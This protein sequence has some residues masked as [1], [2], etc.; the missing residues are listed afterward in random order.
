MCIF[1][2]GDK[3]IKNGA[4]IASGTVRSVFTTSKGHVRVV[5]EFDTIPGMLHIFSP[6]NLEKIADDYTRT[7]PE[8]H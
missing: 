4:Y 3:V 6:E 7:I 5:F 8:F 1:N 2:V